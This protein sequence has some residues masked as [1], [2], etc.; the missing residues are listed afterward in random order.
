MVPK[1]HCC[2]LSSCLER[3]TYLDGGVGMR[4]TET[5]LE[6]HSVSPARFKEDTQTA[7]LFDYDAPNM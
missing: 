5:S 6:E 3:N 2:S 1:V 4:A 7:Y